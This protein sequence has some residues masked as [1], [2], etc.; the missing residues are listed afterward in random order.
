[1]NIS[2]FSCFKKETIGTTS[3][4]LKSENM[5]IT[6]VMPGLKADIKLQNIF[7]ARLSV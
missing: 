6:L 7:L 5:K 3:R 4:T 1:M 2:H